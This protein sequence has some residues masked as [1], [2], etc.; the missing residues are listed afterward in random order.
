MELSCTVIVHMD[1]FFVEFADFLDIH[2]S[3]SLMP[4]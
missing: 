4:P 1:E 3:L 2:G